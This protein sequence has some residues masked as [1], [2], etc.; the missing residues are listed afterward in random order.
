MSV[1]ATEPFRSWFNMP[2]SDL[3]E[4]VFEEGIKEA[5]KTTQY[6][7]LMNW[8]SSC[9][10]CGAKSLDSDRLRLLLD[11]SFCLL[12]ESTVA[13]FRV[14]RT[15]A[16]LDTHSPRP[17][18][19]FSVVTTARA[20]RCCGAQDRSR[21]R[22]VVTLCNAVCRALCRASLLTDAREYLT[23]GDPIPITR[24]RFGGAVV[25]K[26]YISLSHASFPLR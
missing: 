18:R 21:L 20:L 3:A 6:L 26:T 8:R 9:R 22:Q 24:L 4:S 2:C 16:L 15:P 5:L 1:D 12:E 11:R 13:T 7:R 14:C 25:T 17:T 19:R 23:L 10:F